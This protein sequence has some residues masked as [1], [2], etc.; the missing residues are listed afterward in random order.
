MAIYGTCETCGGET[1]DYECIRCYRRR[2]QD[3]EAQLETERGRCIRV[4]REKLQEICAKMGKEMPGIDSP[5][6]IDQLTAALN[7]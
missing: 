5:A 6:I 1:R 3:L 4:V 7:E 2:I